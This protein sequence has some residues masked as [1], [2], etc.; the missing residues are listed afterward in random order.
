MKFQE[1]KKLLCVHLSLLCMSTKRKGIQ[2]QD[3]LEVV[4]GRPL[5]ANACT[6]SS[7][8]FGSSVVPSYL[9]LPQQNV[10][11]LLSFSTSSQQVRDGKGKGENRGAG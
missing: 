8:S 5:G 3:K 11:V 9:Y 1:N 4:V 2:S 10:N 6:H 7:A